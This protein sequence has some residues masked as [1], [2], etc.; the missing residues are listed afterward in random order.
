MDTNVEE[1]Y[2]HS[3]GTLVDEKYR[4]FGAGPHV[5]DSLANLAQ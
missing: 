5:F 2:L 4:C 3:M 1:A